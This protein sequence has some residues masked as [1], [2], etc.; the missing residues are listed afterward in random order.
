MC[1]LENGCEDTLDVEDSKQ[2]KYFEVQSTPDG[3]ISLSVFTARV[4]ISP[5]SWSRQLVK[6]QFLGTSDHLSFP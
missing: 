2:E 3:N 6:N 1:F 4:A 5:S